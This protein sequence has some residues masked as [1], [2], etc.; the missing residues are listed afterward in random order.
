MR[1]VVDELDESSRAASVTTRLAKWVAA[2]RRSVQNLFPRPGA[3]G[4]SVVQSEES[5]W[6]SGCG[7]FGGGSEPWVAIL[8][9]GVRWRSGAVAQ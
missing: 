7:W 1:D 9:F 2:T 6:R 3:R 8:K 4:F 5:S